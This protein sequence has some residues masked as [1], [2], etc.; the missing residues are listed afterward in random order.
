MI[1]DKQRCLKRRGDELKKVSFS[2]RLFCGGNDSRCMENDVNYYGFVVENCT[3]H[4]CI[5]NDVVK[6]GDSKCMDR[7]TM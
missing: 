3:M 1:H 5:E 4:K 2:V 6:Q 7:K